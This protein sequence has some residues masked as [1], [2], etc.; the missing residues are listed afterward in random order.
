MASGKRA[1]GE[2]WGNNLSNNHPQ[3]THYS[4][5]AKIVLCVGDIVWDSVGK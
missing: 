1:H 4:V 2:I 3:R 5:K